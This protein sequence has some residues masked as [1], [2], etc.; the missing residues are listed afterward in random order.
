MISPRHCTA[1]A[2]VL[3][4]A[5][6]CG[7]SSDSAAAD[8]A[9]EFYGAIAA[10]DGAGACALL[11]PQT[12]AELIQSAQ[13]PCAVAVLEEDIPTV[14]EPRRIRRFGNQALVGFAADTA[15]LAQFRTGWKVVAV[16]CEP[17]PPAPYDCLVK[18]R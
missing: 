15:F 5:T 4:A 16:A 1:A 12:R 8:A 2:V 13:A 7:T 14:D 11:A 10:G 18:G 6:A 17:R 3:V 9:V